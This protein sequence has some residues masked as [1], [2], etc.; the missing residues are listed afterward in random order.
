[1]V[2]KGGV[3]AEKRVT[4]RVHPGIFCAHERVSYS[5]ASASAVRASSSSGSAR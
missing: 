3:S 4:D 2:K 1:M 5:T